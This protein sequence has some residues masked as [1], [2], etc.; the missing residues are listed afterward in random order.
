MKYLIVIP[1]G[2]G[3]NPCP[4]LD[5]QTPLEAADTPTLDLLAARGRLGRVPTCPP[6]LPVGA[7]IALLT[8]L[9]YDPQKDHAG[10]GALEALGLGHEVLPGDWV[11]RVSF[12]TVKKGVVESVPCV[13]DAEAQALLA[14]FAGQFQMPGSVIRTGADGRHVLVQPALS[15]AAHDW[16]ALVTF[17][18][19]DTLGK[20][21]AK[22]LPAGG[23]LGPLLS[24]AVRGSEAFLAN[25]DIN[26]TRLE[27]GEA[28]IT[29]I[30]PWGQGRLPGL[31]ALPEQLGLRVAMVAAP[32]LAVGL[33]QAMGVAV[34]QS[35]PDGS[36]AALAL[37]TAH[38]L[39]GYD[40]VVVHARLG[41]L[42][43][44]DGGPLAKAAAIE[45]FDAEFMT[46]VVR[47][48]EAGGA[49]WRILVVP[50]HGVCAASGA[51]L[52]GPVP[53]LMAGH[54]VPHVVDARYTE[55][56]AAKGDLQIGRGEQLLEHFLKSGLQLERSRMADRP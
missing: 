7:D 1:A 4:E 54:R 48:L 9:G 32:G 6:P 37:A 47:A 33:A 18:P 50:D 13:R 3:D 12:L 40:L 41:D 2:L 29:H 5:G 34:V 14:A 55:A 28:P 52:R 27:M 25:H 36:P 8:L 23:D 44:T 39:A 38:A 15:G 24:Q 20:P 31:R 11:L 43:G 21:M 45:Y 46:P 26:L 53:L 19:H 17:A 16:D 56:N 30:W 51:H 10:R 49:P 22:H 35:S 42:G